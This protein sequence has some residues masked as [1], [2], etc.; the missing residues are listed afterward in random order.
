MIKVIASDLDDTLLGSNHM[1][2]RE[3]AEAVKKVQE[4]GVEFIVCTGRTQEGADIVIKPAGIRCKCV[5]ASGAE[6]NDEDGNNIRR[7]L[8]SYDQLEE[9]VENLAPFRTHM[10]FYAETGIYVIVD[11]D[12]LEELI[13]DD[14]RLF[15]SCVGTDE[16]IR[17]TEVYQA[18]YRNLTP[19]ASVRE[20]RNQGIEIY[21]AFAFSKSVDVINEARAL[22]KTMP[23]INSASAFI[24]SIELTDIN[25]TKGPVL[26]DFIESQ[27][28]T[29]DEVMILGDSP[30]D[31]SMFDMEF[32]IRMAVASGYQE[33]KDI[34]THITLG[35]DEHGVAYAIEKLLNGTIDDLKVR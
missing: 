1:I 27:G 13:M 11:G 19:L 2:S 25:G 17:E 18:H 15:Y 34:A 32:G 33:I 7:C 35:N 28:Y 24:N 10:T 4:A 9:L 5:V 22:I 12:D 6:V 31:R 21:K 3:N 16:E 30:N 29:M 8:M 20:F 23:T 26:K 14:C